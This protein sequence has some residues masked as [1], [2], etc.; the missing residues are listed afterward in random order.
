MIIFLPVGILCILYYFIII[1]YAGFK[2]TFASFWLA[3]GAAC[4]LLWETDR[5]L[6]EHVPQSLLR[7]RAFFAVLF[8]IVM[9]YFIY[10]EIQIVGQALKKA[11]DGAEVVIILGA[12]VKG[13]KPSRSLLRRVKTGAD[14][15]KKNPEAVVIVSGGRG[16]GEEI[17]EAA[18]MKQLLQQE[19]IP[20]R[21][22]VTEDKS[23]DTRE[24]IRNS[25]D[26]CG[27]N[28]KTAVVTCGYHMYRALAFVKKEGI[29]SAFG[30]PVKSSRI[31]CPNYYVREFFA[32]VKYK[33]KKQI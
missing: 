18:C 31:L 22:I 14:Y 26:I 11:K 8:I 25:L 27:R 19:G 30:C 12:Q 2:S 28:K 33:L 21:R 1:V 7:I 5:F 20:G 29:C 32:V 13:K 4:F 23:R 10:V 24:N 3:V 17:S 15:L 9:F 16:P 6:A